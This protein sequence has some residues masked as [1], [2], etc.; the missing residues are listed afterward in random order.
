[1]KPFFFLETTPLRLIL[2][3]PF[4]SQQIELFSMESPSIS[5]IARQNHLE[6]GQ[7]KPI[8]TYQLTSHTTSNSRPPLSKSEKKSLDPVLNFIA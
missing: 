7:E 2:L 4:L 5:A 6:L 1:M 3:V 8:G